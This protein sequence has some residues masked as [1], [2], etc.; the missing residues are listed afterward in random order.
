MTKVFLEQYLASP[1]SSNYIRCFDTGMSL[2]AISFVSP[3]HIDG[4][5]KGAEAICC[6]KVFF[7]LLKTFG[8]LWFA[9]SGYNIHFQQQTFNTIRPD[10]KMVHLFI[11]IG[12]SAN[13]ISKN[14][15]RNIHIPFNV[16]LAKQY[17]IVLYSFIKIFCVN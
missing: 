10:S 4:Q 7:S 11:Y 12:F 9:L 6:N 5:L 14:I 13:L 17:K 8:F 1:R 3:T 15:I 16:F 2:F